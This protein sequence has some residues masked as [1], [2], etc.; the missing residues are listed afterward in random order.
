MF[1]SVNKKSPM[2]QR[3]P[4][5]A[6][7]LATIGLVALILAVS[8]LAEKAHGDH[9]PKRNGRGGHEAIVPFGLPA[10]IIALLSAI[11][12]P[13]AYRHRHTTIPDITLTPAR[14]TMTGN[15]HAMG[16]PMRMQHSPVRSA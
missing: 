3:T 12:G 8:A 13:A 6:A 2:K 15:A 10:G 5:P 7:F 16:W 14:C 9:L 1:T 4:T 11:I